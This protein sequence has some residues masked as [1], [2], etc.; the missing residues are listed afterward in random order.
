[1]L[2]G[3]SES[4]PASF[5]GLLDDERDRACRL[6][7]GENFRAVGF[8]VHPEPLGQ[9]NHNVLPRDVAA[10]VFLEFG[11]VIARLKLRPRSEASLDGLFRGFDLLL[12]LMETAAQGQKRCQFE[13][14]DCLGCGEWDYGELGLLDMF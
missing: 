1:M 13:L 4:G 7:A 10:E 8:A 11:A 9:A 6:R 14:R 3:G 5:P 2:A 12:E